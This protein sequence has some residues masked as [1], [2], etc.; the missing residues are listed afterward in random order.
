MHLSK[1]IRT[2]RQ[3][4]KMTQRDVAQRLD[5]SV[6]TVSSWE[7]DESSSNPPAVPDTYQVRD[8]AKLFGVTADK[9]L[10]LLPPQRVADR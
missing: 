8:L 7:R 9:L 2:E 1:F 5:V 6:N 10:S 4:R 3:K